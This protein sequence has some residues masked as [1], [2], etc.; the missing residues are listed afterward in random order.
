MTQDQTRKLGIEFERRIIEVNPLFATTLKLDT[1]TIYSILSEYQSQYVKT[2][3]IAEGQVERGT[4]Q[5]KKIQDTLKDLVRHTLL[6]P[7]KQ[8]IDSDEST[9][10]FDLPKDY[11]MYI[12]SNSVID[13]NYKS[14]K[15]LNTSV[16]T[17]NSTIKQ[18]E[19]GSVIQTFYNQK[20]IIRNPLVVLESTSV[21]SAY[22]KVIHDVYTNILELDLVY[23]CMPYAFNVMKYDDLD[24][25]DGAVHSYCELPY[26]CFEELVSGAVDMYITQYKAKL[27]GG[28]QRQSQPK[29]QEAE[30]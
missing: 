28:N 21:N 11:A 13:K 26:S 6:F 2:L 30:Q 10:V 29:E 15:V 5:A 23:Y 24:T 1:D 16:I 9:V 12:R 8:N 18:E 14:N 7:D 4:R 22:I 27:S 25:S 20:C 3:Y 17:P 19:V